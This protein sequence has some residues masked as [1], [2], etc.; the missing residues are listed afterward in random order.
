MN[1][2]TAIS[3][4]IQD[5]QRASEKRDYAQM[6]GILNSLG[7]AVREWAPYND[8][9][10]FN[11][12]LFVDESVPGRVVFETR[13]GASAPKMMARKYRTVVQDRGGKITATAMQLEGPS[14]PSGNRAEVLNGIEESFELSMSRELESHDVV[15]A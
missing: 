13:T 6:H 4:A 7:A 9:H 1:V 2:F 3:S 8:G 11:T 5:A 10:F 15:D 12:N 14:I